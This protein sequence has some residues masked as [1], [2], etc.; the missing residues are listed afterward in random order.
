M[1]NAGEKCHGPHGATHHAARLNE[2][3]V[4][5]IRNWWP[6]ATMKEIAS[7]YG[8]SAVAVWKII[9]RKTW[10]KVLP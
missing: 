6:D 5:E 1:S 9:H 7:R 3:K 8:I 2:D 4:K 10:K